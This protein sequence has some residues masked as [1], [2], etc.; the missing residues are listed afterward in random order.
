[1]GFTAER[2]RTSVLVKADLLYSAIEGGIR[3]ISMLILLFR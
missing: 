2:I 3:A 1:M